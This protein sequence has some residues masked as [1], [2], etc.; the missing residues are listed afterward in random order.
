MGTL[1]ID[2]L[3]SQLDFERGAMTV[4]NRREG[5]RSVPLHLLDRLVV[6][7]NARLSGRLLTR[8]ADNGTGITLMPGRGTRRACF[9]QGTGHGDGRRRLGQCRLIDTPGERQRWARRLLWLRL[10]GQRRVLTAA[11]AKRPDSRRS[12][13][14]ACRE[15]SRALSELREASDDLAGLRGREGAATARFF[16][17]YRALFT[18]ELGFEGRRRRPPPD[19][20][21][22]ALSLGYALTHGDA[23]RAI[24]VT[25]LD[26]MLGVLH[27]P[28]H[29]RESLACDLVE[30]ARSRV[31]CLVWRLFAER[32]LTA[33]HFARDGQGM[34]LTKAGRAA[35]FGSY[36]TMA[37]LHRRWLAA[38]ARRF[39]GECIAFGR[40]D[41][42]ARGHYE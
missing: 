22:A 14:P 38:A 17:A 24:A 20:V 26:P 13:E 4:R 40:S 12:L 19:P 35:F 1:Y 34:R 5:L 10:A 29:G 11:Q 42:G 3:G 37:P 33:A 7:G 36:E 28:A 8:L 16:A 23:L 41:A 21:N 31:E 30:L 18:S 6:I 39:A 27:D 15:I 25:G 32:K 9:L 2:R